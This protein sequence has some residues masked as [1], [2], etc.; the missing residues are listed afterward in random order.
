ML[1]DGIGRSRSWNKTETIGRTRP[2]RNDDGVNAI[3]DTGGNIEESIL[4]TFAGTGN[5]NE[6]AIKG[7][8]G[9]ARLP[10]RRKR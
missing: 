7:V 6:D 4:S 9:P 8:G 10:A 5:S 1:A 2:M 3:R